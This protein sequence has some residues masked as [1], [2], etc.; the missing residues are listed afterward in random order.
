MGRRWVLV[1][2]LFFAASEN[3][4]AAT[5]RVAA[6]IMTPKRNEVVGTTILL[7][8]K[9]QVAGQPII[10]V[11]PDFGD[12]HYWIQPL[13][14]L[15]GRGYFRAEVRV[16]NDQAKTGSK[17]FL[18]VVVLRSP[19]EMEHFK[20]KESIP[21]LPEGLAVSEEIPVVLRRPEVPVVEGGLK[22]TIMRP[23]PNAKVQRLDEFVGQAP[24]NQ[25]PVV[26]V[27]SEEVNGEWWV[28][29]EAA[30]GQG[31]YFKT[32]LHFGNDRTPNGTRFRVMV[33]S[34]RNENEAGMLRA[35]TSVVTLPAGIPRSSEVR[36]ELENPQRIGK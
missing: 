1:W 27:R 6:Q 4:M 29:D 15:G 32:V 30:V 2:L 21:L 18:T 5:R 35:G 24:A 16:G 3:G 8:G 28:Q 20:G 9:T 11:R 36:V 25:K 26:L 33:V 12:K 14:E 23:Q 22:V 17:F 19:T 7:M 13:P 10:L 34:P 31:G